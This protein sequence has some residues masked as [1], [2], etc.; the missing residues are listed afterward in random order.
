MPT[1]I[2]VSLARDLFL[3]CEER[4]KALTDS[5]CDEDVAADRVWDAL[6]CAVEKPDTHCFDPRDRLFENRLRT[7]V[8]KG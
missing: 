3:L 6:I 4:Y 8:K 5:G 1:P 2:S 7:V